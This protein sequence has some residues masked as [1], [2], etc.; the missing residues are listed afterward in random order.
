LLILDRYL[1]VDEVFLKPD[2]SFRHY[3]ML[4]RSKLFFLALHSFNGLQLSLL[5]GSALLERKL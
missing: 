2:L 3:I 4:S 5:Y 1:L